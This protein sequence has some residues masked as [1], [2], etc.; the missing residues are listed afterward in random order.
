MRILSKY[1][2]QLLRTLRKMP[3][4][5]KVGQH[6]CVIIST[7]NLVAQGQ[8]FPFYFYQKALHSQLGITFTEISI[9]EYVAH[10]L[11]S[12]RPVSVVFLQP[13]FDIAELRLRHIFDKIKTDYPGA[14]I[15][16][17][18]C[19]APLD[20]RFAQTV[21]PLVDL[22]VK[23]QVFQDRSQYGQTTCGDTNLVDYYGKLYNLDYE[24]MTVPV[25]PEFFSK[26]MVGPGFIT[27]RRILPAFDSQAHP[28]SGPRNMD[29]HARLGG[30][31][32]GWYGKM[33][34][35]AVESVKNISGI[36]VLTGANVTHQQYL[37][38]LVDSKLCFS[39]FGFGEVCWRDYE[40]VMCGALLIK[41]DMSH[42]E[43]S[44]DIFRPN[45]AYVPVKWDF[46][47]LEEKVR[48]YLA[49]EQ[50]RQTIT[51]NAYRILREYVVSQGFLK[52]IVTVASAV[53]I[54]VV[55]H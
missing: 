43:T 41:P 2:S 51:T 26:L 30:Q 54:P 3:T 17:L 53:G 18:D 39:P 38:E 4:W 1:K 11:T 12:N 44:P 40:A 10:G 28:P 14:K 8:I 15:V 34:E 25:P 31:G 32:A 24:P 52:H 19:F 35:H 22:Y 9:D 23:K 42:I 16:F 55:S 21:E 33:R 50:E 20:L 7:G 27:S 48:Y 29:M 47:D 6:H 49:N 45:H 13:W 37:K 5:G 36:K 46:S